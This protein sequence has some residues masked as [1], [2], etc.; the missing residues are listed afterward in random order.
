MRLALP[1]GRNQRT[2]VE[3]LRAVGVGLDGLAEKDRRLRLHLEQDDLE[4]LM[5]KDWDVPL[6]VEYG[7]AD[8]GVVGS[9]VL[10][11]M[12]GDLLEPVRFSG[13]GS[14]LS[15]IGPPGS[16]PVAGSQIRLATKYPNIARRVVASSS[17]GAEIFRLSG[18]VELGPV[19]E[20]CEIA[21]DIVQTGTTL[22]ENGLVE[23]QVIEQVQPCLVVNRAS[24]Q[25]HRGR[26]NALV[27]R[28]EEKELVI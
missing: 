26:L 14:R 15:L 20:L 5:L 19:L 10:A 1:K 22:R 2:A 11:E 28:L 12:D 17:W 21:L 25:R 18:S 27:R 16:L 23:L 3:A 13:G 24:Y 7:V 4:V 8:V 9:D 6:Y